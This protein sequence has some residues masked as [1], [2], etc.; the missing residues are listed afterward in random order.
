MILDT[1]THSLSRARIC[2]VRD[3]QKFKWS[4]V[5]SSIIEFR[6]SICSLLFLPFLFQ[7][8][9]Y[10]LVLLR[11]FDNVFIILAFSM[12]GLAFGKESK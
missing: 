12:F 9:S 8:I 3:R 1:H 7:L 10:I 6:I 2:G 11:K 4:G 5:G